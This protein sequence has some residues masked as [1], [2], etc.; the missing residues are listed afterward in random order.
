MKI[1]FSF[2]ALLGLAL[3][4]AAATPI[5]TYD[6][7]EAAVLETDFNKTIAIS[8]RAGDEWELVGYFGSAVNN[9]C[10]GKSETIKGNSATT[11][12]ARSKTVTTFAC[13]DVGINVGWAK[14]AFKLSREGTG[15]SS[16][17]P[18]D[19]EI[20]VEGVKKVTAQDVDDVTFY[21]VVCSE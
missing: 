20:D 6:V 15:C 8:P 12:C 5:A 1:N 11:N 19:K 2:V 17:I 9:Q 14:C 16:S 7:I 3:P 21:T 4:W 18:A 13:V 10:T